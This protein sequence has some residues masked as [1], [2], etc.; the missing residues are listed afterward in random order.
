AKDVDGFHPVNVGKLVMEDK[1]GFVPCTPQGCIHLLEEAGI[2]TSGSN[3]VVIGRSMIVGKPMA[4][5]LMGRG[6]N[7]TVTVAHSRTRE[8]AAVCRQADI[9]VAAIGKP[10]FV[11]A[12]FVKEGAVVID[13]GINRVED[14]SKKRGYRLVGDV[15]YDEVA[16]KCHAITPVPGGVGPMTIALLMSNT[17]KA[18]GG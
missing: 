18:A 8:L 1:S 16:P 9:L 14:S 5:L 7:A 15:A 3:A 4:L 11:T 17:V 6:V 12:D 13:V 2:E 10:E